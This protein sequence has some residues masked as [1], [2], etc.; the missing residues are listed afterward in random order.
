MHQLITAHGR[1]WL[2]LASNNMDAYL[3]EDKRFVDT[4]LQ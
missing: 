4:I 2:L 3:E 1:S